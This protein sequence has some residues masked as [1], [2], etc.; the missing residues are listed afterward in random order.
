V[1]P[2]RTSAWR[3]G[4]RAELDAQVRQ[5]AVQ[6]T[7]HR[8]CAHIQGGCGASIAPTLQNHSAEHLLGAGIQPLQ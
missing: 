2:H 8:H 3:L 1:D 5:T 4:R 7:L 6:A